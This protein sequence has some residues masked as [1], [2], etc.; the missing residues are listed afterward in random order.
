MIVNLFVVCLLIS[1]VCSNFA[2]Q[3]LKDCCEMPVVSLSLLML[4]T[5]CPLLMTMPFHRLS[6]K[7]ASTSR[8]IHSDTIFGSVCH[9]QS[10]RLLYAFIQ[11]SISC[12]IKAREHIAAPWQGCA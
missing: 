6:S 8:C 1:C 10:S 3:V 5:S 9:S 2:K 4:V 11:P 7:L 12:R